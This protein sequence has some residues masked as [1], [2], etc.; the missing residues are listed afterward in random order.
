MMCKDVPMA[1]FKL[2]PEQFPE[3]N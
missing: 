1:D 2:L 3:G